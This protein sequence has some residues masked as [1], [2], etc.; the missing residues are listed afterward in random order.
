M[1]ENSNE[2]EA[3]LGFNPY[4]FPLSSL[5]A[6]SLLLPCAQL[7]R[8]HSSQPLL[9]SPCQPAVSQSA[10]ADSSRPSG[11]SRRPSD[12]QIGLCRLFCRTG[13]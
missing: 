7:H 9:P 12:A 10:T 5:P 2:K 13:D 8:P 4:L 1:R 3:S 11:R 6:A